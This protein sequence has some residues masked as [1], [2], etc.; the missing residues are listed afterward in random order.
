M[1]KILHQT[2]QNNNQGLIWG[3]GYINPPKG[4]PIFRSGFHIDNDDDWAIGP[5]LFDEGM[6][7]GSIN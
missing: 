4:P 3:E 2:R 1:L 7:N 6:C 5:P